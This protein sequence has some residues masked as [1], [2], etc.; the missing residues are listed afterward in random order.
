MRRRLHHKRQPPQPAPSPDTLISPLV[1]D[2]R[3]SFGTCEKPL[4]GGLWVPDQAARAPLS[5]AHRFRRGRDLALGLLAG[6]R[7]LDADQELLV[8]HRKDTVEYWDRRDVLTAL[9]LR[10]VGMRGACSLGDLLL[11]QVQLIAALP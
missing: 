5:G 9:Q 4:P 3:T 1:P 7:A 10:N 8:E 6:G 2:A 11:G